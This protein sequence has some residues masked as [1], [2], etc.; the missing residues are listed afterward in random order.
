MKQCPTLHCKISIGQY[1]KSEIMND[2]DKARL[3]S[4]LLQSIFE[5]YL[6]NDKD[7]IKIGNVTFINENDLII[8]DIPVKDWDIK[9]F[10][11]DIVKILENHKG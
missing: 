7:T 10:A 2:I 8:H 1:L 4:D 5:V 6:P 9:S 11:Q 3:F